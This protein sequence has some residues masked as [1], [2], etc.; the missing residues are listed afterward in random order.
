MVA[1]RWKGRIGAW[2]RAAAYIDLASA[3]GEDEVRDHVKK[4]A[5]LEPRLY[6]GTFPL[7]QAIAAGEV[8]IGLG[9]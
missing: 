2:S 9:T 7:A 8:D 6:A 4:L 5:T 1:D 3:W